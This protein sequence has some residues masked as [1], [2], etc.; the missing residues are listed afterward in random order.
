[1]RRAKF[2]G[3]VRPSTVVVPNVLREHHTQVSLTKDQETV[4]EFGSDR[5]N[6][7][8]SD[9]VRPRTTRRNP[10]DADAHVSEDSIERRCKLTGPISEEEPELTD[11]IAKIHH[12]IAD[13]LRSPPAVRIR[14]RAQQVHSTRSCPDGRAPRSDRSSEVQADFWNP[15]FPIRRCRAGSMHRCGAPAVLGYHGDPASRRATA[16][17]ARALGSHHRYRRS[18]RSSLPG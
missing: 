14:G 7:P 18:G 12:Q 15:L 16:S 4:G 3:M 17:R 9:T 8:F 13:L 1:L 10:D 5:A 11:A 6:E 2:A